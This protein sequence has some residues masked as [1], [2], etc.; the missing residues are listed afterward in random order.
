MQRSVPHL[1]LFISIRFRTTNKIIIHLNRHFVI[2]SHAKSEIND[3]SMLMV[4]YRKVEGPVLVQ[5]LLKYPVCFREVLRGIYE[6]SF[7]KFSMISTLGRNNRS[8]LGI[9]YHH[10][11]SHIHHLSWPRSTGNTTIHLYAL[12]RNSDCHR[13]RKL[14][15]NNHCCMTDLL[16]HLIKKQSIKNIDI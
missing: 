4:L 11:V 10:Q 9:L 14:K 2:S 1:L 13:H 3:I 6:A 16:H 7:Q 5:V 15:M 12:L 8:F